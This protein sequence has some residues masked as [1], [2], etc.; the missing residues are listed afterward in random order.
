MG[1]TSPVVS[2][3]IFQ[4]T[5]QSLS[6]SAFADMINIKLP[7]SFANTTS[8]TKVGGTYTPN[9]DYLYLFQGLADNLSPNFLL[10]ITDGPTNL[11]CQFQKSNFNL[12]VVRFHFSTITFDP[13]NFCSGCFIDGRTSPNPGNTPMAQ[14]TP[15]NY[16]LIYGQSTIS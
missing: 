7:I 5:G 12:Q 13:L 4:F 16:E 8:L 11:S 10:F 1:I 6:Q 3:V 14:N 9:N 2:N 15:I